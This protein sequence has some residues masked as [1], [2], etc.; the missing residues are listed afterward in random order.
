MR[1]FFE[2]MFSNKPYIDR[3]DFMNRDTVLCETANPRAIKQVIG[4]L[5]DSC[6]SFSQCWKHIPFLMRP[7]YRGAKQLCIISVNRT[8]YSHARRAI[9]DMD[10]FYYDRLVVN[11]V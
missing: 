11:M 2:E 7:K 1:G 6:I 10:P 3:R 8:E 4:A 5:N 9:S